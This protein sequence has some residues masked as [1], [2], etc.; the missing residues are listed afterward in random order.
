MFQHT[1]VY[2]FICRVA[3]QGRSLFPPWFQSIAES[4][5]GKTHIWKALKELESETK[6]Q[7]MAKMKAQAA[8][9]EDEKKALRGEIEQLRVAQAAS[10]AKLARMMEQLQQV[11]QEKDDSPTRKA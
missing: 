5:A 6:R 8:S 3:T 1:E 11:N 2:T 10:E 9:D 7:K 4:I